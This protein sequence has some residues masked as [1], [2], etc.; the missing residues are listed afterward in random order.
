MHENKIMNCP[1]CSGDAIE[2]VIESLDFPYFTVAQTLKR[3]NV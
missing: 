1:I 2:D 3:K